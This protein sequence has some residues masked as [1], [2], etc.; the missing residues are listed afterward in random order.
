MQ[1]K[2]LSLVFCFAL[3]MS[4][5]CI[6]TS[7]ELALDEDTTRAVELELAES[8]L[9]EPELAEPE[10][11]ESELVESDWGTEAQ[12]HCEG[13]YDPLFQYCLTKCTGNA[14][15]HPVGSEYDIGYGGCTAA[16]DRHCRD[17]GWGWAYNVC[18]GYYY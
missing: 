17:T 18:W 15:L 9:A 1:K 12:W 14:T 8:E 11:A 6:D 13:W 2:S 5:G 3:L 16:A 4:A 10:L 7:G